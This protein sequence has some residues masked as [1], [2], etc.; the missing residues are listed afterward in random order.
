MLGEDLPMEVFRYLDNR[1]I[2][3]LLVKLENAPKLG[4]KEETLLLHEFTKSIQAKAKIS[5]PKETEFASTGLPNEPINRIRGKSSPPKTGSPPGYDQELPLPEAERLLGEIDKILKELDP[6]S[7]DL[8]GI[9]L[10]QTL[11]PN[12]ISKM[13]VEESPEIVASVLFFTPRQSVQEI[14]RAY[15]AKLREKIV[16]CMDNLDINSHQ[17]REEL[18]RFIRF[19]LGIL[20][21]QGNPSVRKIKSRS[22]KKAAEILSLLNPGESKEILSKI[23]K[24]RPEFAETIIEHYYSFSDFLLLGR[25]SLSRFLDEFHPLVLATAL[26]GVETQLKDEILS[27]V[28]PWIAKKIRLES[29]SLGP[30]SLAEIEESQKGILDRFQEEIDQGRV[31]LWRFR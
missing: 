16:L 3:R 21:T 27:S 8:S 25:T 2:E 26:K 22:S 23:Q 17:K 6:K 31:K 5:Q 18:D 24:K 19:K 10:L 20:R 15:P 14:I 4:K 30:V 13:L 7:P 12:D 11:D 28:E 9:E 1:E 29:D